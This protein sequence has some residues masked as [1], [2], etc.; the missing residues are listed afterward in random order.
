MSR[1]ETRRNSGAG[2][3]CRFYL[4]CVFPYLSEHPKILIQALTWVANENWP[5]QKSGLHSE[6]TMLGNDAILKTSGR[7]H[8]CLSPHLGGRIY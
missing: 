1:C 6:A 4:H 7:N 5:S 2:R 3:Q 8:F